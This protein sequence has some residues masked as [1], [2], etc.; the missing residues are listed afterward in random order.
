MI[1]TDF[2]DYLVIY[3]K[4][5]YTI[6][7]Y[8]IK[9]EIGGVIYSYASNIQDIHRDPRNKYI[10]NLDL[11]KILTSI[12]QDKKLGD[13]VRDQ[14]IMLDN[15]DYLYIPMSKAYQTKTR[16]EFIQ[17]ELDL[18]LDIFEYILEYTKKNQVLQN[19]KYI[20]NNLL[21]LS[22]FIILVSLITLYNFYKFNQPPVDHITQLIYLL[23][24]SG[25][26]YAL[27][28]NLVYIVDFI[29]INL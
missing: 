25:V 20:K 8:V 3:K 28:L 11:D 7:L 5:N 13:L 1:I 2:L 16:L 26:I 12:I 19:K 22:L 27:V 15:H 21:Y 23:V 6:Y 24:F 29:E 17:E 10:K 9:K 18:D 4:I 14:I